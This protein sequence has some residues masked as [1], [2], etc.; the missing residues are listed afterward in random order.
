MRILSIR[1]KLKRGRLGPRWSRTSIASSAPARP[2]RRSVGSSPQESSKMSSAPTSSWPS[3]SSLP[4]TGSVMPST[5]RQPIYP[6]GKWRQWTRGRRPCR[7]CRPYWS[8]LTRA[9]FRTSR[10]VKSLMQNADQ[11]SCLFLLI[12]MSRIVLYIT[13]CAHTKSELKHGVC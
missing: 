7:T 3:V 8:T 12:L 6:P 1:P 9:T 13:T 4:T 2:R 11:Y 10:S 5:A